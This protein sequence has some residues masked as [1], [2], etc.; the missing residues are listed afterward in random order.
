MDVS[1][2]ASVLPS[3]FDSITG[4]TLPFYTKVRKLARRMTKISY[5]RHIFK[6]V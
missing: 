3:V 2:S 4:L 1:V 6:K 5:G